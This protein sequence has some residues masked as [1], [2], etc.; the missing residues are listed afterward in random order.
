MNPIASTSFRRSVKR[1]SGCG[2]I[3]KCV[4][5]PTKSGHRSNWVSVIVT[6]TYLEL[7]ERQY[8]AQREHAMEQL[9]QYSEWWK[10]PLA[11]RREKTSDLAIEP[12][13]FRID[14]GSMSGLRAIPEA[15]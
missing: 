12:V 8:P 14:I 13:F 1:L 9:A 10:T 6:G 11:E 7:H 3:P 2:K 15:K 4:C 5:K